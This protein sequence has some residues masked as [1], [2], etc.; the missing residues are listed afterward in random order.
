MKKNKKIPKLPD[1]FKR[2]NHFKS[3]EVRK[4]LG[5]KSYQAFQDW[6]TNDC[7]NSEIRIEQCG[8]HQYFNAH[9]LMKY[10]YPE[11]SETC[12]YQMEAIHRF[13][14]T[15]DSIGLIEMEGSKDEFLE[16]EKN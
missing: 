8:N 5:E 4:I 14:L 12:L 10:L 2:Y 1:S 16:E 7:F 9:D 3:S 6:H 13:L 11:A 15:V